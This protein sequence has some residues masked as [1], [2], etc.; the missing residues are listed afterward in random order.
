MSDQGVQLAV[1]TITAIVA[2]A[3]AE[4][5]IEEALNAN[6]QMACAPND[7]TD[8]LQPALAIS[9]AATNQ[10]SLSGLLQRLDGFMRLANLAAEVRGRWLVIC[11]DNAADITLA[12]DVGS[13]MG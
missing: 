4:T 6:S 13:S 7:P 9:A 5:A 2:T 1:L 3:N 10:I 11:P 12:A 8:Q